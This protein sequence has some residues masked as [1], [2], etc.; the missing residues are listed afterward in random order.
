VDNVN[1]VN[2]S[3]GWVDLISIICSECEHVL[4]I[5]GN[6]AQCA[7]SDLCFED[8]GYMGKKS[9]NTRIPYR[10][11]YRA[12]SVLRMGYVLLTRALEGLCGISDRDNPA[13][14]FRRRLLVRRFISPLCGE[15][16]I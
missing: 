1:V 3:N 13:L 15:P 6:F 8:V 16:A 9:A 2:V 5:A 14:Q 12:V 10:I 7:G 11:N 4:V